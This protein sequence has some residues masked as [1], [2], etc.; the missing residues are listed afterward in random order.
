MTLAAKSIVSSTGVQPCA[1][2]L[3]LCG[4]ELD[5]PAWQ[6]FGERWQLSRAKAAPARLGNAFD[7]IALILTNRGKAP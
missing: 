3:R 2:P 4:F 1:Q 6:I 7:T 5:R